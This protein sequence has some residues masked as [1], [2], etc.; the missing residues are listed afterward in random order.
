MSRDSKVVGFKT[1]PD[2]DLPSNWVSADGFSS[3]GK[4]SVSDGT[5]LY[6]Q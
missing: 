2:S 1:S 5:N 3:A 4:T 6:G